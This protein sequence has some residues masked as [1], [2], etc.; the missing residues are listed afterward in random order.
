MFRSFCGLI[1][2]RPGFSVFALRCSS[3]RCHV[4]TRNTGARK[5]L[6]CG[7]EIRRI[8]KEQIHMLNIALQS[9]AIGLVC[10]VGG[11]FFHTTCGRVPAYA[12]GITCRLLLVGVTCR[13][14]Q[15]IAKCSCWVLPTLLMHNLQM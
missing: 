12:T 10:K 2:E 13:L 4:Q 3:C 15:V 14:S 8:V 6:Q 7:Q 11:G 9:H 1:G 5:I